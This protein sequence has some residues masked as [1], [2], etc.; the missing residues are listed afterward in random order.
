MGSNWVELVPA[1]H[2]LQSDTNTVKRDKQHRKLATG[3]P[4][5]V[6]SIVYFLKFCGCSTTESQHDDVSGQADG[7][8]EAR[9][10]LVWVSAKGVLSVIRISV[11]IAEH[12][13]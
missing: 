5:M 7:K 6:P 1:P 12:A 2:G 3:L 4:S 9:T 8:V 10:L 11:R 13:F